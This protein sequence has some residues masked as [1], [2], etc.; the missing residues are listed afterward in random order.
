[1][2]H[3]DNHVIVIHPDDESREFEINH[4][5][6]RDERRM[7]DRRAEWYRQMRDERGWA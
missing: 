7:I 1:M 5:L 2:T 3:I 4:E 6:A